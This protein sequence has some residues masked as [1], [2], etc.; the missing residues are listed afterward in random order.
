MDAALTK[1]LDAVCPVASSTLAGDLRLHLPTPSAAVLPFECL[2]NLHAA[3][4]AMRDRHARFMGSAR[5]GSVVD[6]LSVRQQQQEQLDTALQRAVPPSTVVGNTLMYALLHVI[7]PTVSLLSPDEA[8][9][10]T[11]AFVNKT[12]RSIARDAVGVASSYR[13]AF[14]SKEPVVDL[15]SSLDDAEFALSDDGMNDAALFH[16]CTLMGVVAVLRRDGAGHACAIYPPTATPIDTAV[17]ITW[18]EGCFCLQGGTAPLSA[19]QAAL[20]REALLSSP[21]M[22]SEAAGMS[23]DDLLSAACQLAVQHLHGGGRATKARLLEAVRGALFST[24]LLQ[25]DITPLA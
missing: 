5:R 7:D 14:K 18:C 25:S 13:A 6:V 24:E 12:A 23:R 21:Q 15:V 4:T 17:L 2:D 1:L 3:F 10:C 19:V 11:A 9:R 22:A 16:V 8:A 20:G